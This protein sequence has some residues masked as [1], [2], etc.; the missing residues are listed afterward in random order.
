MQR[1][2]LKKTLV[3]VSEK[4]FTSRFVIFKSLI[5]IIIIVVVVIIIIIINIFNSSVKHFFRYKHRSGL[6]ISVDDLGHHTKAHSLTYLLT[7]IKIRSKVHELA[8]R[9]K[10]SCS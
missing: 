9:H 8:R 4:R 7:N 6:R 2:Y 1:D 5:S 10:S 3:F